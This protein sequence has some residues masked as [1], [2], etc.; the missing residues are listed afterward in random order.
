MAGA[1]LEGGVQGVQIPHIYLG[2]LGF[3]QIY[4]VLFIMIWWP[5]YLGPHLIR[6]AG[7]ALEW[8]TSIFSCTVL[9]SST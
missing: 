1:I 8:H 3:I 4:F 7:S 5:F 6:K 2:F 9:D